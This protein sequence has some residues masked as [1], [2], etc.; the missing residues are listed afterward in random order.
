MRANRGIP[1]DLEEEDEW[2]KKG[3]SAFRSA[4]DVMVRVWKGKTCADDKYGP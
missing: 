2:L 1:R 3:K 4:G